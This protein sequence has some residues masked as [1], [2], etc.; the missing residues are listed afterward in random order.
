[1]YKSIFN[2]CCRL[3]RI[4]MSVRIY[5]NKDEIKEKLEQLRE[6]DNQFSIDVNIDDID[7]D[8]LEN[9]DRFGDHLDD[10]DLSDA[11]EEGYD[12][13]YEDGI[14]TGEKYANDTILTLR[15]MIAVGSSDKNIVKKLKEI[16]RDKGEL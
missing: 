7:H 3:G 4:K 2:N 1:M 10:D 6:N 13:G 9:E 5:L 15:D 12:D 14:K 16:L 8:D 11:R